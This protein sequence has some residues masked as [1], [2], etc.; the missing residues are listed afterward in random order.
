MQN[1]QKKNV[2]AEVIVDMPKLLLLG[3]YLKHMKVFRPF[4]LS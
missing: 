4:P 3:L 1:V 2:S